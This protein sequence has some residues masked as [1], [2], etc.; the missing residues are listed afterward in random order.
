M[1]ISNTEHAL[2]VA[3]IDGKAA[4]KGLPFDWQAVVSSPAFVPGVIVLLG[5]VALFWQM[6]SFLPD[7]WN[8]EDGYYSHGWLV[9]FIS[10]F[11]IFKSWPKIHERQVKPFWPAAIPLGVCLYVALVAARTD[12]DVVSSATLVATL[13]SSIWMLAG[14]RWLTALAL[15]TLYLLFAL[16]I[17][18]MAI[19]IYT[20]PLQ[21]ASTQVA[22]QMLRVG[23]FEPYMPD[24][25]TI[26]LSQFT[27][28]VAVPCSGLKLLLALSAFTAFFMMIANL[29]VWGN[30]IMVAMIIPLALFINGLRIALIGVV[31]NIYGHDAG[32]QFHDY[33]GYITLV[34]CF[35]ILFR[36]ARGLGWKD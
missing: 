22:Y 35:I 30:I 33:S 5:T 31:G 6:V 8:S 23:G 25:S 14:T 20:N 3:P 18:T 9:P 26:H 13:L 32:M 34:V 7:L 36:I 19:E 11:I 12:I 17:W 16:P 1:A 21:L 27:L 4:R 15:P 24:P 10:G 28:N 2:E 29:K